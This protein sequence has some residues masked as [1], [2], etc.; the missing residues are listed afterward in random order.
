MKEVSAGG[1]VFRKL[2]EQTELLIIEDR[3][4]RVSLPKG[5]QEKGETIEQTALREVKEET[6]ISGRII[7]PLEVIYYHYY[8]PQLGPVDKEVH[9][10]LVEAESGEMKPQIE[11]INTVQWMAPKDAWEA[12]QRS[13]YDNNHSVIDKAFSI[14]NLEKGPRV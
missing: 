6:G 2:G 8:H 9:Y 5:K 7:E 12:Q 11:E 3:Y 1:V 14:L 10:Y 13:G 4:M